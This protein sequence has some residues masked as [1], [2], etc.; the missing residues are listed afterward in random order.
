[1]AQPTESGPLR[2]G[3]A[4]SCGARSPATSAAMRR[5]YWR[6]RFWRS[7][8]SDSWGRDDPARHRA[9]PAAGRVSGAAD[10]SETIQPHGGA[11][12]LPRRF[13]GVAGPADAVLVSVPVG[14]HLLDRS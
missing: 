14:S 3:S 10:P 7:P 11:D 9:V 13:P 2:G 5:G 6:A 12:H 1:M 8:T 4:V